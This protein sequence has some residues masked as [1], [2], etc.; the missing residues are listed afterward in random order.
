MNAARERRHCAGSALL[1]VVAYT[2]VISLF[3]SLFWNEVQ[4]RLTVEHA[5]AH[6][7]AALCA[8][9]AGI[10]RA[11]AALGNGASAY[12]GD[13]MEIGD[14]ARDARGPFP[15]RDR[16]HQGARHHTG[17]PPGQHQFRGP[18]IEAAIAEQLTQRRG[19]RVGGAEIRRGRS[20]R[21][22]GRG[23]DV[24]MHQPEP[25]G[26]FEQHAV[27]G[28]GRWQQAG[29]GSGR[30]RTT[31][32]AEEPCQGEEERCGDRRAHSGATLGGRA[33]AAIGKVAAPGRAG[34]RLR[35]HR[36]HAHRRDLR[37]P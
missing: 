34:V 33:A 10:E 11:L 7:H 27:C 22:G 26:V 36:R 24:H 37:F 20:P 19:D 17:L 12:A 3:A 21:C 23:V 28:G 30:V 2:A 15:R 18:H 29:R 16:A 13:E 8:A 35:R 25:G 6:R 32:R 31:G 14:G 1:V 5:M 9:E 4:Q